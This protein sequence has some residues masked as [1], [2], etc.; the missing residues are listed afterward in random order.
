MSD[1]FYWDWKETPPIGAIVKSAAKHK[2]KLK[3]YHADDGSD[4][5]NCIIASN[6]TEALKVWNDQ[7]VDWYKELKDDGEDERDYYPEILE[8]KD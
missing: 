4:T 2:G 5:Y 7:H 3:L 6:K 8:W 1:I